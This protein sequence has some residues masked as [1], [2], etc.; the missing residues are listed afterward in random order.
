MFLVSI[1]CM[2]MHHWLAIWIQHRIVSILI[3]RCH[4]HI[5]PVHIECMPIN[6]GHHYIDQLGKLYMMSNVVDLDIDQRDMQ[7][8]RMIRQYYSMLCRQD[9]A[10]M[11]IDPMMD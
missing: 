10:H 8:M 11:T 6:Q 5:G 1:P 7:D 9:M 3:V 4:W 2:T